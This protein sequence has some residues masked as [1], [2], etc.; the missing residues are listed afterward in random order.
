[1]QK[2]KKVNIEL[3]IHLS[4]HHQLDKDM[5]YINKCSDKCRHYYQLSEKIS[6]QISKER[7]VHSYQ[8]FTKVLPRYNFACIF[9]VNTMSINIHIYICINFKRARATSKLAATGTSQE[10]KCMRNKPIRRLHGWFDG[11]FMTPKIN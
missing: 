1:M 10:G 9:L 3:T 7:S 4:Q 5:Y 2:N 6:L 8:I 11:K